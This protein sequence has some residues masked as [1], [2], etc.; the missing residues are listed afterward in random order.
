MIV[1]FGRGI[2]RK[3]GQACLISTGPISRYKSSGKGGIIMTVRGGVVSLT[4][5]KEVCLI[6]QALMREKKGE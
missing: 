6:E 4:N 2:R 1:G 3:F 5:N